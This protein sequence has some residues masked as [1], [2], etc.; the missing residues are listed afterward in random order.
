MVVEI[1]VARVVRIACFYG[2]AV[3]LA[4]VCARQAF[5]N[6]LLEADIERLQ[7]ELAACRDGWD[8]QGASVALQSTPPAAVPQRCAH[9]CGLCSAAAAAEPDDLVAAVPRRGKSPLSGLGRA[10]DSRDCRLRVQR[11]LK[12]YS[13]TC[14]RVAAGHGQ[15]RLCSVPGYCSM[16]QTR[17]GGGSGPAELYLY[18]LRNSLTGALL[19][20][21]AFVP[22][23]G[24]ALA[25]TTFDHSKRLNGEDWPVSGMTMSGVKRVDVLHE[26]LHRAYREK[27]LDG[28][29]LEAGV[30]RGGSCIYA[31][32]FL[33][34]YGLRRQVFVVDSFRGLPHKEHPRDAAFWAYLNYVSVPQELVED[35]FRRYQL[36]DDDVVFVKGWFGN[37]LPALRSRV[38]SVAILRLDGDMY[39]ST[40]EVLCSMYDRLQVGGYWIVDDWNV[41]SA[42]LAVTYFIGNH[43]IE[44]IPHPIEGRSVADKANNAVWFEKMAPVSV[45]RRWC[46]AELAEKWV[47]P[48]AVPAPAR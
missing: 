47:R 10:A 9:C 30:W 2:C 38:G 18:T 3:V 13:K 25:R 12:A 21:D 40:L 8:R 11:E 37:T 46:A 14:G 35:H 42:I 31:K 33:R 43:S 28:A 32:G 17:G 1:S 48:S 26:L 7:S 16:N 44:D 5:A 45:D 36:Y 34:A 41:P 27:K 24:S 20:T 15:V 22:N 6:S 4:A 23:I 19:T 29:F 39:K